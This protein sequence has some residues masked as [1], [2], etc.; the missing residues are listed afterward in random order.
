M[1]V[2]RVTAGSRPPGEPPA[3][4]T[5]FRRSR[6]VG[7]VALSTCLISG[8]GTAAPAGAATAPSQATRLYARAAHSLRDGQV[9]HATIRIRQTAGAYSFRATQQLWIDG[10]RH[11]ARQQ[12]RY[13][14]T[15]AGRRGHQTTTTLIS[16]GVTWVD[17]RPQ[18]PTACHHASPVTSILI[19]CPTTRTPGATRIQHGTYQG[20]PAT[21]LFTDTSFTG[22]DQAAVTTQR[23]LLD[24]ATALPLAATVN[25][26]IDDG[27]LARVHATLAYHTRFQP[28]SSLP[29]DFFDPASLGWHLPDPV[30][31][32][33]TDTPIY[34]LG[35]RFHP[36]QRP[37]PHRRLPTLVLAGVDKP[38]APA[39]Y[40]ALLRYAPAGDPYAP[41]LLTII[42]MTPAQF[43][44]PH[45]IPETMRCGG[46]ALPL[47]GA[48][49]STT[50]NRRNTRA[51]IEL[52]DA[53][54]EITATDTIRDGN[55]IRSAYRTRQAIL[56]VLRGLTA[57]TP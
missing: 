37:P 15:G 42:V 47:P 23:T 24:P 5:P 53:V 2:L 56:T 34:W 18:S 28:R 19:G 35:P 41:P 48:H 17:G 55:L 10:R 40:A 14:F 20:H 50:C 31:D 8:C 7:T 43:H 29:A 6:V 49:V 26:T 13:V 27:H 33:P 30:A 1:F 45:L 21:V 12:S 16:H 9:Y 52:P 38:G 32:L 46:P 3:P 11:T 57:R 25:G 39:L 36:T 22:S 44:D 4:P 51:R 54:L